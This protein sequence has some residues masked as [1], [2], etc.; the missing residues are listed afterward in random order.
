MIRAAA[1]IPQ[2]FLPSQEQGA[3]LV[4]RAILLR[5]CGAIAARP[6]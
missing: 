6:V 3:G 2:P 4:V 5:G 1:R